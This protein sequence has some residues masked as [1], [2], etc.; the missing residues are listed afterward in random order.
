M[1]IIMT[2]IELLTNRT[3]SRRKHLNFGRRYPSALPRIAIAAPTRKTRFQKETVLLQRLPPIPTGIRC[4]SV[5]VAI[6]VPKHGGMFSTRSS[7][8]DSREVG[9][10]D[11]RGFHAGS[12]GGVACRA[13]N[14][15]L[16][17]MSAVFAAV[18][19]TTTAID[20]VV[21]FS[22]G[23]VVFCKSVCI[24]TDAD[25]LV[26]IHII[27]IATT[28]FQ[29][30]F[31][32]H[33]RF[34]IFPSTKHPRRSQTRNPSIQYEFAIRKRTTKLIHTRVIQ[35]RHDP[36]LRRRQSSNHAFPRVNDEFSTSPIPQLADEPHQMIHRIEHLPIL[37]FDADAT[38]D[39]YRH[40]VFFFAVL[41]GRTSH[42]RHDIARGARIVHQNGTE[43][44]LPRNPTA[45]T[46]DV[47]INLVVSTVRFD[48]DSTRASARI[49]IPSTDLYYD[50]R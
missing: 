33:H 19:P 2:T 23:I 26:R 41:R 28:I 8:H 45:G 25:I 37:E 7:D 27:T 6:D 42:G 35:R 29:P 31:Y 17:T 4:L 11:G 34:A 44:P 38:L 30:A 10:G 18:T 14:A 20:F 47:Q 12:V 40:H 3:T 9:R 49:G 24:D 48:D 21:P 5:K 39:R 50:G 13:W 22:R 36:I 1:T 43:F 16:G 46:I 15:V 32:H